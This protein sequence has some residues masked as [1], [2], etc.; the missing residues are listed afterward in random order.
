[1]YPKQATQAIVR[2]AVPPFIVKTRYTR[3]NY[4]TPALGKTANTC[5]LIIG[6]TSEVRQH[7]YRELLSVTVDVVCMNR[8]IGYACPD[9]CLGHSAPGLFHQHICLIPP[10]EIRILLGPY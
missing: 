9:Q 4:T 3:G 8:Q 10:I 5:Y 1:M 7:E 2:P 6:H